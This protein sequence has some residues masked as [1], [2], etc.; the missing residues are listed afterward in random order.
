MNNNFILEFDRVTKD[1]PGI[2]AL[3]EVSF[4]VK[5][6]EIHGVCGEN[7]AG[8]ST[9]MKILAGVYPYQSYEGRVFFNGEEL[10][11]SGSSIRKAIEKGIAIVYQELALVSQMTV[12]ENIYL[13][14][15]PNQ[16][17]IINWNELYSKTQDIL[18][19]YKLKIPFA[20]T[21]GKL[22]VG[23]QQLVE[24][25]KALSEDAKLLIL[26]EPTS[27]LTETEVDTLMSIL[28]T[29]KKNGVTCIYI[30][31]KIEEFFRIADTIT[32]LRD[33]K[34]INTVSSKR[35]TVP[36]IIKMMVGREMKE[37]FPKAEHK[38]EDV[39]LEVK[40]LTAFHP[41]YPSRVIVEDIS[42]C[43]HKGEI[44]GIAGLMGSGRTELVTTLF[45]EYGINVQGQ[46]IVNNK[47]FDIRSSRHAMNQGISLV[48]ENRKDQGL[49]LEQ[50][51]LENISL[52]NL[53]QFS[54][55]LAINKNQEVKI[56]NEVVSKLGIKLGSL[57]AQVNSLS[58]GNQQKVV[59][60][61][62]LVSN[63]LILIM[64][65]PT[66]GI[67]VGAKYEIY[68]LMNILAAS[69]VAIIMVSSE[70]PEI[71]ALSDTIMV[72][73]EARCSGILKRKE[74]TQE[75]IMTLATGYE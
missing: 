67:D 17:G 23:Q 47:P 21:V 29:L 26:D 19:K 4:K 52:P 49:I 22:G 3:S 8:K 75:R 39:V 11:F 62:W 13:G 27:A 38:M 15:E 50:S 53:Q 34:T 69:G 41:E 72:M 2:R 48:P 16:K 54:T 44:L 64:D 70:L 56:C 61:K 28:N 18:A 45:G 30:S 74:A 37:R 10:M 9:L 42:F 25:T 40:N 71:M 6:G 60:A 51:V 73:H 59:I 55:A 65:E 57:S 58:G 12:G 36:A 68:K 24:I 33:G 35:T 7:G 1:F 14:R 43:L 5:R 66:R 32:V 20:S 31:H 63:P 46:V